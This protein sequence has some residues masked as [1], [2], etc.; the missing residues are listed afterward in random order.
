MKRNY[1]PCF[2]CIK[3]L[4]MTKARITCSGKADRVI[5]EKKGKH[6]FS[7]LTFFLIEEHSKFVHAWSLGS[8]VLNAT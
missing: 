6:K 1:S 2:H 5:K 4:S 7:K 3:E 8:Y